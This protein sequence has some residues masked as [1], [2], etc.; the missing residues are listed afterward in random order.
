MR[1][2]QKSFTLSISPAQAH[3]KNVICPCK[4]DKAWQQELGQLAIEDAPARPKGKAKA[5]AKAKAGQRTP[6]PRPQ[7][8]CFLRLY[9]LT[10]RNTI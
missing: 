1:K 8:E 3:F 2:H 9:H 4:A 6:H 7:N 10:M 5:K